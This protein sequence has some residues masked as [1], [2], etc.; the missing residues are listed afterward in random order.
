MH[1]TQNK[2]IQ[3]NNPRDNLLPRLVLLVSVPLFFLSVCVFQTGK[4]FLL[5]WE[6]LEVPPRWWLL[7]CCGR[8]EEWLVLIPLVKY[9]LVEWP[10]CLL[11]VNDHVRNW[12]EVK[13]EPDWRYCSCLFLRIA[14]EK[15]RVYHSSGQVQEFLESIL[16][17]L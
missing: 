14:F 16:S 15:I 7:D 5:V 2:S 4:C 8:G 11:K 3:S 9:W 12:L 13:L 1:T 17:F 6:S 10:F